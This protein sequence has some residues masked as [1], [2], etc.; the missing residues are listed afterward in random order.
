MVWAHAAICRIASIRPSG[1]EEIE[2]S[3]EGKEAP[4]R[5]HPGVE[6]TQEGD[7]SKFPYSDCILDLAKGRV[8]G[9]VYR[10]LCFPLNHHQLHSFNG[11]VKVGCPKSQR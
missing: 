3:E 6:H 2:I 4:A 10:V 7:A 8:V 9:N 5:R 11:E 1:T